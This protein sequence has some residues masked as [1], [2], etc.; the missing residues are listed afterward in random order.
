MKKFILHSLSAL[1]LTSLITV[2]AAAQTETNSKA[3]EG[4]TIAAPAVAITASTSP[5]DL[6]KAALA[7]QGGDKFKAAK[8]MVLRGSV[9]L[10]GPNSTQSIPGSFIIVTSGEKF[11]MEVDARPLFTFKQIFDGQNSYSSLPGAEVA[12][13]NKFGIA[14]L[15]KFEGP[16]Y[17]VTA[18]PDKKK[19][20]G[21]RISDAD[22]NATDF[23]L[24]T[25]TGRVVNFTFSYNGYNFGT[26]N[27]KF[28][29]IDGVL[30]PASFTQRIEM[31]QGAA[32]AEFNA[33]D[34][35]LNQAIGDD[36]FA[37]PN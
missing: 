22:G 24:D 6:A 5:M 10:Y 30:V 31:P 35:K 18:L 21:F 3:G 36:V 15:T 9:D 12:P 37:M 13:V 28:K 19:Q 7:A 16:G 32:F 26:E 1:A 20:R 8:N 29:E 23:Y 4:S 17:T 27:K 2:G 11:R 33:K 14:L 34:I 25:A